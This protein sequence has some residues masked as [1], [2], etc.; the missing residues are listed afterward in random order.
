[1]GKGRGAFAEGRRRHGSEQMQA[2]G[3]RTGYDSGGRPAG[4]VRRVELCRARHT[5][6][7]SRPV[8][9]MLD[10]VRVALHR[11]HDRGRRLFGP[12]HLLDVQPLLYGGAPGQLLSCLASLPVADVSIAEPDLEEI[13]LHYYSK[14]GQV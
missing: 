9:R 4:T 10:D 8:R 12:A 1:M 3:F 6:A 5:G 7:I 13:F 14:E 11:Q 2:A